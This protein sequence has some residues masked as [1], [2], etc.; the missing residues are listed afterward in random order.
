MS[1]PIGVWEMDRPFEVAHYRV[2]DGAACGSPLHGHA[3]WTTA[4]LG[5]VPLCWGCML[6]LQPPPRP[7]RRQRKEKAP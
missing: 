3:P 5:R 6:E 7:R 1:I 4:E 2:P